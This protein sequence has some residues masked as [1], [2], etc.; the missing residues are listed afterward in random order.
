[1]SSNRESDNQ[2]KTSLDVDARKKRELGTIIRLLAVGVVYIVVGVVFLILFI[3][4]GQFAKDPY[5]AVIG[6][7][8]L[9]ILGGVCISV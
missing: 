5:L 6:G 8:E 4:G 1:M 7:I 3:K 2:R 9:L